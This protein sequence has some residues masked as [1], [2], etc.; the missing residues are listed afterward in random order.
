MRRRPLPG[1]GRQDGP[2]GRWI[3]G[4][5]GRDESRVWRLRKPAP[6]SPPTPSHQ[7]LTLADTAE[8]GH[9]VGERVLVGAWQGPHT[10]PCALPHPGCQP[11]PAGM[12]DPAPAPSWT[13]SCREGTAALEAHGCPRGASAALSLPSV[14]ALPCGC[15]TLQLQW[16]RSKGPRSCRRTDPSP[17]SPSPARGGG[18]EPRPP[19]APSSIY[20]N[21]LLWKWDVQ[22]LCTVQTNGS[23]A[24]TSRQTCDGGTRSPP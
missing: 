11:S 15:Q 21:T 16:R 6:R 20:E 19:P 10:S 23:N 5:E 4:E 3:N 8:S 2:P 24:V 7:G 14:T 9:E 13:P 1:C 22:E 18:V 12:Q 17:S